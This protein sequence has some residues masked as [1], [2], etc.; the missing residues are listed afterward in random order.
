LGKT[1]IGELFFKERVL[2][3]PSPWP[4]RF[5]ITITERLLRLLITAMI[6]MFLGLLG[7]ALLMQLA[8]SRT[9]H[10]AEQNRI[11]ALH[12]EL[13][14]QRIRADF[15]EARRRGL[16]PP[17][18]NSSYLLSILPAGSQDEQRVFAVA[19]STGGSRVFAARGAL[20]ASCGSAATWSR[21]RIQTERR[22]PQR[23]D[24]TVEPEH[25]VRWAH[26]FQIRALEHDTAA[27]GV[28]K[29]ATDILIRVAQA[30]VD[31]HPRGRPV[32]GALR[33]GVRPQ[34]V[35]RDVPAALG[36]GR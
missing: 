16:T 22:N 10:V 2:R 8:N 4:A 25:Q 33:E 18:V 26:S 12:A 19:S 11:S 31:Q 35:P 7:S 3:L 34:P 17:I 23:Y 15:A 32:G 1:H 6:V 20:M 14:A 9:S 28:A 5:R 24:A 13:V 21:I 29:E 30:E 36:F 27:Q